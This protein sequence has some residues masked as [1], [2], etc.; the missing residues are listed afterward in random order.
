[1]TNISHEEMPQFKFCLKS[2]KKSREVKKV[3]SKVVQGLKKIYWTRAR[4][5][6]F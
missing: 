3:A 1:M 2:A 4:L 6:L 5:T